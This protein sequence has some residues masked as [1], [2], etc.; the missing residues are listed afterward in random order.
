MPKA[1]GPPDGFRY[2]AALL[3]PAE[4][5]VLAE[6]IQDLPFEAFN[7]Q[8][9]LAKRRVVSYGWHYSYD[10]RSLRQAEAIPEFLLSVRE[11][12]A[13]FAGVDAEQLAQ[14]LVTEYRPGTPI[15]WHRDKGVYGD[16]IGISLLSSCIFRF[17]RK[18]GPVWER[19][20]L[21][22][23][24]GSVYLLTGAA[25]NEWEHSIPPV[26]ALRYSITFRSMR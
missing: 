4:E 5:R 9:Y 22:V 8:G 2:E 15:G 18:T 19:Y 6:R 1:L 14:A 10:D 11:R 20:S 23:E 26:P 7:F 3:D 17:R 21:T 25:R 24:P 16:V 12:A 13:S